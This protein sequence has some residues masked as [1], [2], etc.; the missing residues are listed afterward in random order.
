MIKTT[1]QI[2]ELINGCAQNNRLHQQTMYLY[3]HSYVAAICF[4]YVGNTVEVEELISES[5]IKFFKNIHLFNGANNHQLEAQLKGWLKRLVANT[6]IDFLR[7]RHQKAFADAATAEAEMIADTTADSVAGLS[8]K[9]IIACIR[10]LSPAYR[11]IFNL[12]VI[13][14]FTHEEIASMLHIS[15]GAS[16]SSLNK[17]KTN[18]K[19][20]ITQLGI[21]NE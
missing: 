20:M 12:H 17:A 7:K 8:Y 14:G 11:T 9:D 10:Q 3:L 18:L 13:E 2:Q 21:Q 5:F 16:K 15:I 6:C 4:R 19:K 1:A